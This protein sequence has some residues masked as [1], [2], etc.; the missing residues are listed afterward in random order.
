MAGVCEV[1][2]RKPS[3]GMNVSHSHVRTKRTWTPN[4][5]KIRVQTATGQRMRKNVCTS[6]IKA[7]KVIKAVRRV[8]TAN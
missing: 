4:I 1:C 6:C 2:H 8:H 5:Q 7:G 3:T